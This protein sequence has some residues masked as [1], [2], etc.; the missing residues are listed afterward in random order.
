MFLGDADFDL[1]IETDEE[2]EETVV[3]PDEAID[4]DTPA[5]EM[6][7]PEFETEVVEKETLYLEAPPQLQFDQQWMFQKNQIAQQLMDRLDL[8][9]V[10][11]QETIDGSGGMFGGMGGMMGGMGGGG[12]DLEELEE[13]LADAD[14]DADEIVE[15]LEAEGGAE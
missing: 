1:W 12:E 3:E 7:E 4:E 15:E 9:R 13:E 10:I 6:P 2:E 11:I 14:V 5:E 8:D